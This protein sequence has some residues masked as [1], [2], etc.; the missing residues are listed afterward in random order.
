MEVGSP[1]ESPLVTGRTGIKVEDLDSKEKAIKAIVRE[2]TKAFKI[3]VLDIM[4]KETNIWRLLRPE[5]EVVGDVAMVGM[6]HSLGQLEEDND[7]EE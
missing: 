1:V 3:A 7:D 5:D 6:R 4:T 2:G